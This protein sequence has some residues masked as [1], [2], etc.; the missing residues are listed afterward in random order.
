MANNAPSAGGHVTGAVLSDFDWTD[1]DLSECVFEDCR[2]VDAQLSNTNLSGARFKNCR[3]VRCRVAHADLRE[4][5]FE[6]C[7][8]SDFETKTGLVVAFSEAEQARFVNCDLTFSQFD[9][10]GLYGV[11][12]EDCNLRGARF[13]RADFSRS[14]SRNIVR[15]VAVFRDCNLELAEMA[16]IRLP[17]CELARCDLREADLTDADLEG[18]DLS[19]ANLFGTLLSGAKLAGADLRG[20][21]VSGLDLGA[22]ASRVGLKINA[23]QQYRLLTALGI[24]VNVDAKP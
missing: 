15:T 18:A 3:I 11:E 16:E 24:D 14:F 10:S 6:D 9:R 5:V 2:I 4:A 1:A 8:F 19:D 21:E 17:G 22:L 23:D 12:M 13:N 20:A 7:G